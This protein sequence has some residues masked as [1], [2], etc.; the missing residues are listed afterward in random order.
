MHDC[1]TWYRQIGSTPAS[2]LFQT[3]RDA[4]GDV[5]LRDVVLPDPAGFQ[6]ARKVWHQLRLWLISHITLV[7]LLIST[8]HWCARNFVRADQFASEQPRGT[9][10]K[11]D[12][13]DTPVK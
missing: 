5:I 11:P 10:R 12:A 1:W 3:A 4:D 7:R 9:K 8:L 2:A 6:S 13:L